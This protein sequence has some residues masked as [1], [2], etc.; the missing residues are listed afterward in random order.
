MIAV[1]AAALSEARRRVAGAALAE[2]EAAIARG[3]GPDETAAGWVQAVGAT[4]ERIAKAEQATAELLGGRRG[5]GAEEVPTAEQNVA[6]A[7]F[8]LAAHASRTNGVS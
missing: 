4:I 7:K 1:D 5:E 2:L 3:P 6:M 8:I